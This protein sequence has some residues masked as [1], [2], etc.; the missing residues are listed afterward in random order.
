MIVKNISPA[1]GLS[2]ITYNSASLLREDEE[3]EEEE[4]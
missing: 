4:V 2:G 3:E 1:S